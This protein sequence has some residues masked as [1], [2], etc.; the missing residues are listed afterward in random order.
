MLDLPREFG[1]FDHIVTNDN[2][3]IGL[4]LAMQGMDKVNVL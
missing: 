1:G 2:G 3:P 4:N